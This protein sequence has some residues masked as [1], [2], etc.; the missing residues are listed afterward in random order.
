MLS[1]DRREN[2][3]N[4]HSF[5]DK[6]RVEMQGAKKLEADQWI[7]NAVFTIANR[8]GIPKEPKHGHE[9]DPDLEK[10]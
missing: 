9:M 4:I 5:S 3:V 10:G 8:A 7:N 2:E 6:E 1:D